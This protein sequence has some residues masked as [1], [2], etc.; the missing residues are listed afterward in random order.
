MTLYKTKHQ[1]IRI[2]V[3]E[4][5]ELLNVENIVKTIRY[6]VK[7]NHLKIS[8]TKTLR[9]LTNTVFNDLLTENWKVLTQSGH[10]FY[11]VNTVNVKTHSLRKIATIFYR[12]VVGISTNYIR[13]V[14]GHT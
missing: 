10:H 4:K 14:L 8:Q 9:E 12:D 1:Y 5:W 13:Q 6:E 11:D 3:L 7:E 2:P